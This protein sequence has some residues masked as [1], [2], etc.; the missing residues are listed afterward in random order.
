MHKF[1]ALFYGDNIIVNY[2]LW[3]LFPV[4]RKILQCTVIPLPKVCRFES[5]QNPRPQTLGD[6]FSFQILCKTWCETCLQH[7][8]KCT[9]E[10]VHAYF[11]RLIV[12]GNI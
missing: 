1:R 12:Y 11:F 7:F 9:I 3:L 10:L 6:F 5:S 8:H 4:R 2:C